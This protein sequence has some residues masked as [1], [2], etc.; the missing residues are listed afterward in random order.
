MAKLTLNAIGSRYGSIDALNAN[1]DAIETALENT[2]SR[3]GTLPNNMD[4]NFD[5]D[6]NRVINMADAINNADAVTLRQVNG[7]VQGASSGIIASLRE[8]FVATAGQTVFNIASFT[9]NPGSNN[10]AVYLDGVRQ[11]PGTSY[12][13][14]DNNT[15]TFSAGL[16]VGALVMFISNQ[17][18]DTANLNAALVHYNPAGA[19][20]VTTT[21]QARLRQTVSVKD[22]GAVGDGIADDTA[23]IQATITHAIANGK[24]VILGSG[25]YYVTNQIQ[26]DTTSA[27]KGVFKIVGGGGRFTIPSGSTAAF[28]TTVFDGAGR[29]SQGVFV[30]NT[31]ND[32]TH[33]VIIEGVHYYKNNGSD[34]PATGTWLNIRTQRNVVVRD[35][36]FEGGGTQ[37]LAT[38][39]YGVSIVDNRFQGFQQ[40]IDL[41]GADNTCV[42]A[43][44]SIRNGR[45]GISVSSRLASSTT[46]GIKIEN[47]YI[48]SLTSEGIYFQG[49]R[50]SGVSGNYFE[51]VDQSLSY[52]GVACAII[53]DI[54]VAPNIEASSRN[55]FANNYFN[56]SN[57]MYVWCIS[58]VLNT[59]ICNHGF[60]YSGTTDINTWSVLDN[61]GNLKIASLS[62]RSA[63]TGI[64]LTGILTPMSVVNVASLG[65]GWSNQGGTYRPACYWID[66]QGVVHLEGAI[67]GGAPDSTTPVFTLPAG[68][69]P[70]F[71]HW[72]AITSNNALGVLRVAPSGAVTIRQGS[73]T[74]L[75]SISG[76]TFRTT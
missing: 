25:N 10:L 52:G 35:C 73:G 67:T 29:S 40:A 76:I 70:P 43:R 13:E 54:G 14:T 9:Y 7:I 15:I 39:S 20:A 60:N 12:T 75:T 28:N 38:E 59:F 17:S 68:Y 55:Y 22:F 3:D 8:N 42:I 37:I 49:V 56:P 1:F 34:A 44:N 57:T 45:R 16:H 5:M 47:N 50:S 18:V 65:A 61:G 11:Y 62:E 48:E 4:A 30:I 2:L 32:D 69:R 46:V 51:A 19:G 21:V 71:D 36:V 74:S 27:P 64:G 63:G 41:R 26:I 23:A 31:P 58:G 53:L 66:A 72:F 24:W 33:T 6:S